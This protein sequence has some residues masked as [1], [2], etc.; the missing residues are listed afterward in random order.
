MK[1]SQKDA[2]RL[3]HR[4]SDRRSNRRRP[5][6]EQSAAE[7]RRGDRPNRADSGAGA[8]V[9]RRNSGVVT[10]TDVGHVGGRSRPDGGRTRERPA[11]LGLGVARI[12]ERKR[13]H[14]VT[15]PY[16]L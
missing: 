1:N 15:G 2:R 8:A 11:N 7:D 10:A 9:P 5:P 3:E 12:T 13:L 14:L 16:L 4:V 6:T